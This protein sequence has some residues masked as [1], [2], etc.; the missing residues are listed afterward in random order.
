TYAP[1]ASRARHTLSL[2]DALPICSAELTHDGSALDFPEPN[3]YV[4][5]IAFNVIAMAGTLVDD[6]TEETN[7]EQ[8]LRNE[9]RKILGIPDLRSE[10]HTS[11]L[12]SRF[13]LVCRR[14]L[15]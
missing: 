13:D 5:P 11:E 1:H 15:A 12:Q 2:H 9:S 4:K 3:N 8:K 14:L 7:E 6:G 10:E